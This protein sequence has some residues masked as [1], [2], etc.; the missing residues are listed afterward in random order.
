MTTLRSSRQQIPHLTDTKSVPFHSNQAEN[1]LCDEYCYNESTDIAS[2]CSEY[3]LLERPDGYVDSLSSKSP[4]CD[5]EKTFKKP[6]SLDN[7]QFPPSPCDNHPT[8]KS[9][10]L[11]N[12]IQSNYKSDKKGSSFNFPLTANSQLTSA[13]DDVFENK[14]NSVSDYAFAGNT[15]Y[16][17][18][19]KP[20]NSDG[21]NEATHSSEF[22]E[23]F[24]LGKQNNSFFR[25]NES[26]SPNQMKT[27]LRS[28]WNNVKYGWRVKRE[29]NLKTDSAAWLLGRCYHNKLSDGTQFSPDVSKQLKLDLLSKIWLTYRINFPAIPGTEFVSDSGWGCMLR[30]GQMMMAQALICH[31]L[32]RDWRIASD[33]PEESKQVYKMILRWFGDSLSDNSPF[34]LHR[35]VSMGENYGRKAGDWYGPT[36]AAQV[37][38]DAL[39]LCRKY[40]PQLKDVCMHVALDGIVF[41][42][43]IEDLCRKPSKCKLQNGTTEENE[44]LATSKIL[45]QTSEMQNASEVNMI[46]TET[47]NLDFKSVKDSIEFDDACPSYSEF[48]PP[49]FN[50]AQ[51]Y[52]KSLILFVSVR[53]GNDKINPFYIPC[54]KNLLTYEQCIGIIGGRPKHA[55]YFIGWQDDKLIH[56]DPHAC[57]PVVDMEKEDFNEKSFHSSSIRMISF[58]EM[59]PSCAIGF[60]FK[61]EEEYQ[62]FVE[63]FPE[64]TAPLKRNLDYPVFALV[65]GRRADVEEVDSF[66]A[67]SRSN[68]SNV[69]NSSCD[70]DYILL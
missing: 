66:N 58:T 14:S 8:E 50:T 18:F 28:M 21:L 52:W 62:Y 42:Q 16:D 30:C 15:H 43:D 38:R 33:Q 63:K 61:R 49:S 24:S 2:N 9:S 32:H 34:S 4:S 1:I 13:T 47:N 25:K 69:H 17:K 64:I 37:L 40:Y 29:V 65:E 54:L 19:L 57:Q 22:K 41:K 55:L 10:K 67:Y 27:K 68:F 20:R 51:G 44:V 36:H 46:L 5:N 11:N 23:F 3:Q 60:Y 31:F 56:L 6:Y 26:N 59:D 35:L 45:P 53:L 48:G 7:V 70:E 12:S 39:H